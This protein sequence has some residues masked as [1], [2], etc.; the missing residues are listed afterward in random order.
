MYHM[1]ELDATS[2]PDVLRKEVEAF[3]MTDAG[4]QRAWGGPPW[5]SLRA[6]DTGGVDGSGDEVVALRGS[7]LPTFVSEGMGLHILAINLENRE[8]GRLPLPSCL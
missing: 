3:P 6:D 7:D 2:R 1:R 8:R 5:S 4:Y